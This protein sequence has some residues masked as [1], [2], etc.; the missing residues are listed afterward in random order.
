M[1]LNDRTKRFAIR[2]FNLIDHIPDTAKG[3]VIQRQ[4]AAAASSTAPNWS[5]AHATRPGRTPNFQTKTVRTHRPEPSADGVLG[6]LGVPT[7][8]HR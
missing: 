5:Q 2:V 8:L 7:V 3:R 4:L 6:A 1:E